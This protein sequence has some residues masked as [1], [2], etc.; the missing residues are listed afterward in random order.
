M[1]TGRNKASRKAIALEA[2]YSAFFGTVASAIADAPNVDI[3]GGQIIDTS[4]A[5][6][7]ILTASVTAAV[8]AVDAWVLFDSISGDEGA[9]V[10]ALTGPADVSGGAEFGG[11]FL[12]W[13]T[14]SVQANGMAY[15]GSSLTGPSFADS[16]DHQFTVK[17]V[18]EFSAA[19]TFK[20]S[21]GAGSGEMEVLGAYLITYPV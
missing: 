12:P 5:T 6:S 9:P 7:S 21:A 3:N 19:G 1:S 11:V 16:G 20:I 17:G 10:F 18:I 8:W 4:G 13:G 15:N 2:R 14:G